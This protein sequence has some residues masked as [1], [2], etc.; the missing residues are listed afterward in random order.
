MSARTTAVLLAIA[1]VLPVCAQ[2][3]EAGRPTAEIRTVID[4]LPLVDDNGRPLQYAVV[5]YVDAA[6]LSARGIG[7]EQLVWHA[8][9]PGLPAKEEGVGSPYESVGVAAGQIQ[10]LA[11][12]TNPDHSPLFPAIL[13]LQGADDATFRRTWSEAGYVPAEGPAPIVWHGQS[14]WHG[15]H[16]EA[17]LFRAPHLFVAPDTR[18]LAAMRAAPGG[19]G[20]AS[21]RDIRGILDAIDRELEPQERLAQFYL[22]V[23]DPRLDSGRFR[24]EYDSVDTLPHHSALM[25][26]EIQASAGAVQ[27]LVAIP[28]SD[29]KVAE[30]ARAFVSAK[31]QELATP[32]EGAFHDPFGTKAE[33]SIV[34][35]RRACV[36]FGRVSGTA[37]SSRPLYPELVWRYEALGLPPL[38]TGSLPYLP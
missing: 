38:R 14:M 33:W 35:L 24:A 4:H 19:S 27:G 12:L 37:G 32:A 10:R 25:I 28:W 15:H 7:P 36:L 20:A 31:W 21:R 23:R 1:S 16:R 34:R 22:H 8:R 6:L 17:L 18:V 9:L 29:C 5:D 3:S 30:T 2:G 11:T 26:G 13:Q